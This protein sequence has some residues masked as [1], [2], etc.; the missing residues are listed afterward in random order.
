MPKT[1]QGAKELA[2][3]YSE[4][5]PEEQR[6]ALTLILGQDDPKQG[7][8]TLPEVADWLEVSKAQAFRYAAAGRLLTN[9]KKRKSYRIAAVSVRLFLV[10][11]VRDEC[12]KNVQRARSRGA[13]RDLKN[14]ERA[15]VWAEEG[16]SMLRGW[17]TKRE[18]SVR[19]GLV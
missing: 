9:G 18:A 16:C 4:L 15:L 5:S 7:W 11:G 14:W 8:I 2:R 1:T 12:V 3:L 6:Q 13:A 17:V 10:E 19:L